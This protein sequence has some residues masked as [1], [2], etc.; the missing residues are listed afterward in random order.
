ME[1]NQIFF[2][3]F[4]E[5]VFLFFQFLKQTDMM[6]DLERNLR[7]FSFSLY[8]KSLSWSLFVSGL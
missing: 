6:Q 2:L 1:L 4:Q 5:L 3:T 7:D 8:S